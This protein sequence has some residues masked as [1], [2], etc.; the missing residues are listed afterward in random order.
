MDLRVLDIHDDDLMRHVH[1]VVDRGEQ[2]GRDGMPRWTLTEWVEAARAPDSGERAEHLGVF[3]DETLVGVGIAYLFLLDNTDKAWLEVVVDPDHRRRGVGTALLARLVEI[4]EA[5]GRTVIC[6]DAKI[7]F[8]QLAEHPYR[9]FAERHGFTQS[10]IEVVRHL[11]LPVEEVRLQDWADLAAEK[12]AGY[13]L[14]TYVGHF[15]GELAESLC[16]LLGQLAVDAPTGD[17]DYEEEVM[18][19][20]RL[21]ERYAMSKAMA[22]ETFETVAVTPEGLVAAQS[23]LQVPVEGTDAFQWGTFVHREHRGHRL[24]LAVKTANLRAMQEQRSQIRRVVTQN[25]ETNGWMISINEQ[26]GFSPVEASVEFL[27]RA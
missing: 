10:N 7:P 3:V 12:S 16:V 24:G 4:A 6:S 27:R 23:T 26:I 1:R 8:E 21:A 17:V 2:H 19:P 11:P 22:R 13:R 5:D 18:T 14:E 15:P 20:E 25:G 9:S